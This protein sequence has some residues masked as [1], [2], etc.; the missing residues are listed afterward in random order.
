MLYSHLPLKIIF[1]LSSIEFLILLYLLSSRNKDNLVINATQTTMAKELDTSIRTVI[2]GIQT[3][4][5]KGLILSK[6]FR[7]VNAYD[8]F[9]TVEVLTSDYYYRFGIEMYS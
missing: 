9:P 6:S 3:L 4:R 1:E 5:E 2:R 7:N 8:L